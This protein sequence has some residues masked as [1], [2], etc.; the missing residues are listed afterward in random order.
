M[1]WKKKKGTCWE[2]SEWNTDY[3]GVTGIVM[4][5]SNMYDQGDEWLRCIGEENVKEVA[6]KDIGSIISI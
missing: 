1:S 2:C 4:M 5:R 6:G 3:G